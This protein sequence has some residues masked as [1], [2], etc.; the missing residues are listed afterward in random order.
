MRWISSLA[1]ISTC[2][3]KR[4]LAGKLFIGLGGWFPWTSTS[5]HF[6]SLAWIRSLVNL[7]SNFLIGRPA[8]FRTW[9]IIVYRVR[10]VIRS[11]VLQF[12]IDGHLRIG[13]GRDWSSFHLKFCLIVL[14]II[15]V[16]VCLLTLFLFFLMII[17]PLLF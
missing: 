10:I 5:Y 9:I 11:L 17:V 3:R 14:D 16:V 1:G 7:L 15:V 4:R 6:N 2:R 8:L 12:D 13:I